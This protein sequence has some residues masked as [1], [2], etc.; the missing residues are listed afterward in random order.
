MSNAPEQQHVRTP[1]SATLLATL[2][3]RYRRVLIS[4]FR[5]RVSSPAEAEDLTQDVFERVLLSLRAGPIGNVE[6]LLFRIGVNLLRDR[7][8]RL[9][10]RGPVEPVPSDEMADFAAVLAEDLCP[11]R[12][13]VGE[14]TLQEVDAVLRSLGER[15]R[16]IFYL[17]RLERLKVREIAEIYGVSVSAIEKQLAR[18]LRE[19]TL[20]IN[21]DRR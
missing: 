12:V 2:D 10:T 17:H 4:Y 16:A 15:T 20:R 7:A 21:G 5:R 18:A 1:D 6:A 14:R 9:R 13:V 11:E 3:S 8:R 19:L